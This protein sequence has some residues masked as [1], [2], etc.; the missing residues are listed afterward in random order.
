M[1]AGVF[2]RR[3]SSPQSFFRHFPGSGNP[4]FLLFVLPPFAG[5]KKKEGLTRRREDREGRRTRWIPAFA[6]MTRRGGSVGPSA[7]LLCAMNLRRRNGRRKAPPVYH[8]LRSGRFSV[9]AASGGG[10][11]SSSCS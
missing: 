6:G 11:P 3:R 5:Q 10:A 2:G 9:C 4:P 7:T 1:K 8:S